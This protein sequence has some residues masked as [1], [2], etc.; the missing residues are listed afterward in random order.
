[1]KNRLDNP[2]TSPSD[3]SPENIKYSLNS[4]DPSKPINNRQE[5]LLRRCLSMMLPP[6]PI[7]SKLIVPEIEVK[8]F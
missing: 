6:P 7:L 8:Y 2:L 1:V 5:N 4:I 3:N